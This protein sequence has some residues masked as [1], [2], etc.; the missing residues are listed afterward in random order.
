MNGDGSFWY[1]EARK[2]WRYQVTVPNRY[3]ENGKPIIVQAFAT[4]KTEAR[5][6]AKE[7]L[8]LYENGTVVATEDM[9]IF[10]LG[11]R[12]IEE[13]LNDRTK[14]ETGKRTIKMTNDIR[15][16]LKNCCMGKS[17]DEFIFTRSDGKL[18]SRQMV[19][20]QFRRMNDKYS[21]IKPQENTKV[22]LHS[23]RHTYATRCIESGMQAKVLQ[24]RLGHK[25]IKT[26]YNTYGDVFDMFE[27]V[28]IDRAEEYMN[29]LGIKLT[30]DDPLR[31]VS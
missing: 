15:S 13:R 24:Y 17:P 28:S 7:K 12:L 14:T 8:K 29:E 21:F 25:D 22:D 27:V 9:T 18:I 2:Q 3:H 5:A 20:S 26:T 10:M 11:K 23:L 4:T 6:K 16:L 1:S 30:F 31:A 19:Y